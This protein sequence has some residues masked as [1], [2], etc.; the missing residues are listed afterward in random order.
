LGAANAGAS[1]WHIP[2]LD[3][4]ALEL[5]GALLAVSG[6]L[7]VLEALGFLPQ[8]M[9]RYLNRNRLAQTIET[10]SAMGID[11]V[12]LRRRNTAAGLPERADAKTL[13]ERVAGRLPPATVRGPVFIGATEV[14]RSD[15]YVDLMG[16]TTDPAVAVQFARDLAAHW[17]SLIEERTALVDYD[18]DFIV[19]PKSGSPFLGYE[20]AK[21][22]GLP[23]AVHNSELKFRKEPDAFQ[24]HFDCRNV[25]PQGARALV[26]D[27]S[28][29]GGGK[30]RRV[31]DD[32]RA[33]NY[34]VSDM[35]VVFAP[36]LK[37]GTG[38]DA[39]SRLKAAD[40]NLHWIVET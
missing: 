31:V 21:I 40:V 24:A 17:R 30:A 12:A 20:F 6:V 34:V 5:I 26:V 33:F 32:L 7:V 10:L 9:S 22:L 14:A 18:V 29:T 39:Q 13:R 16:A 25:P 28:S 27:D 38:Q 36:A 3:A 8:F 35:L 2:A 37:Q 1:S 19:T 4:P 11:V 23:F 15:S